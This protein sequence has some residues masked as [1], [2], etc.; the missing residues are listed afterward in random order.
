MKKRI[1]LICLSVILLLASFSSCTTKKEELPSDTTDSAEEDTT[2]QATLV[3]FLSKE[4]SDA[5]VLYSSYAQSSETSIAKTLRDSIN[6]KYG[7]SL[8][9]RSDAVVESSDTIAEI[10]IGNTN[11]PESTALQATLVNENDYA[12]KLAGKKLCIVGGNTSAL[13]RG[14]QYFIQTWVLNEY[15]SLLLEENYSYY[16][17]YANASAL[18]KQLAQTYVVVY[19]ADATVDE[20]NAAKS[21]AASVSELAGVEMSAIS[22]SKTVESGFLPI[23]YGNTSNEKSVAE[24]APLEY[25][26][27]SIVVSETETLI[28]GGSLHAIQQASNRYIELIYD[29][30]NSSLTTSGFV[31]RNEFSKKYPPSVVLSNYD[32]FVPSWGTSSVSWSTSM[33]EKLVALTQLASRCMSASY[34]GDSVYYPAGSLEA[35]A[36]ALKA[37]VDLLI[38][39]VYLTKDDI[40]VISPYPD[41]SYNTDA[42]DIVGKIGASSSLKI[43]DWTYEQIA[44]VHLKQSDG[45]LTEYRIPTLTDFVSLC[46]GR[47]FLSLNA[48]T[49]SIDAFSMLKALLLTIDREKAVYSLFVQDAA[50]YAIEVPNLLNAARTW[51]A[52]LNGLNE[53]VKN[54]VAYYEA[55]V[56]NSDSGWIRLLWKCDD[57]AGGDN[58]SIWRQMEYCG[59]NFLISNDI[60]SL[61]RFISSNYVSSDSDASQL[62]SDN[63]YTIATGSTEKRVMILSDTH[64]YATSNISETLYGISREAKKNMIQQAIESEMSNRGLDAVLVLGDLA[65]DNWYENSSN[66]TYYAKTFYDDVLSK[67]AGTIGI[68]VL[69]GNHDSFT[70]DKWKEMFG[71][72]KQYSFTIG[73]KAFLMCD[74]FRETPT[75]SG[76]GYTG[77]DTEWFETQLALYQSYDIIVCSHYFTNADMTKI[78]NYAKNYSIVAVYHGHTH[79]Y[80]VDNFNGLYA[81]N[82][83]SFAYTASA[84]VNG[85]WVYL[86]G[87]SVFGFLALT[88]LW[89][90]SMLEWNSDTVVTYHTK[91]AMTYDATNTNITVEQ[92]LKSADLI[93]K[94]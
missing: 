45:T 8:K 13:Q 66:K 69:A 58:E 62:L 49:E 38:P 68:Y 28:A 65:T 36:S 60:V 70:N 39:T 63:Q 46:A 73:N 74:T 15:D 90:Y 3:T 16:W 12:I 59:R 29:Y 23:L 75:A 76:A 35:Y 27:Y 47:C 64:Y 56:A 71:T 20:R 34:F 42:A 83:G 78:S 72:D 31:E 80:R 86:D 81:I 10:L 50:G 53:N 82:D 37:G 17:S 24:T 85:S 88:D 40:A 87:T 4:I 61:C 93:L 89:G 91:V 57:T 19:G 32:S 7:L 18:A 79:T 1:L 67:Y 77:L 33:D 14:V 43:A 6:A 55:N 25:F 54:L 22:D 94:K 51:S 52:S 9:S 11:R 41:L 48:G 30:Q 5:I 21:F 26:D 84:T 92:N 44:A 2:S